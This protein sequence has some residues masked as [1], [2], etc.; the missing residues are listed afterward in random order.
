MRELERDHPSDTPAARL[1]II[2]RGRL[3]AALA[4]E[5]RRAGLEV[6]GPLG[7]ADTSVASADR[8]LASADAPRAGANGGLAPVGGPLASADVVL[9]CVPDSEIAAAAS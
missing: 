4:A 3:G 8:P 6:I 9:L 7:R 1:A 2:G 5:L